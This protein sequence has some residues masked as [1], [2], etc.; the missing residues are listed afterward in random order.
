MSILVLELETELEE[1][2][3]AAAEEKADFDMRFVVSWTEPTAESDAYRCT[4][5][6]LRVSTRGS[7]YDSHLLMRDMRY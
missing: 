4:I 5:A 2:L 1:T 6:A 7:I 3:L